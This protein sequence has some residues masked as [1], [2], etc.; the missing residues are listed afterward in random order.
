MD[1][2]L[3]WGHWSL[4]HMQ[5]PSARSGKS[6]RRL[7]VWVSSWVSW[8]DA[9]E[10]TTDY[11]SVQHLGSGSTRLCETLWSKPMSMPRREWM[12]EGEPESG[13][14]RRWHMSRHRCDNVWL[15]CSYASPRSTGSTGCRVVSAQILSVLSCPC[16]GSW[17]WCPYYHV[18]QLPRASPSA[19]LTT[20]TAL[21]CS[22][23]PCFCYS[24]S[25]SSSYWHSKIISSSTPPPTTTSTPQPPTRVPPH[26]PSLPHP[27]SLVRCHS[28]PSSHTGN[29]LSLSRRH[30]SGYPEKRKK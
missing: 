16:L 19:T 11:L 30:L 21:R 6:W 12:L 4:I 14:V 18:P 26:Y 29:P 1:R 15:V 9:G 13:R 20:T 27:R 10:G 2:I 8:C 17:A 23:S 22:A 25:S 5:D 7:W 3:K 24:W 28:H